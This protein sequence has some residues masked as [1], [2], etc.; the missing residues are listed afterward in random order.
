[1]FPEKIKELRQQK[2]FTQKDVAE[3]IGV[4]RPAYTAYEIGKRQPDFE[5]L[6]K[7]A[8]LYEV[9]TDYLLGNEAPEE[10]KASKGQTVAAHIDE[11]VSDEEMEDILNY[12]EFIRQ[13]HK[14]E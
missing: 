7:I 6:Q 13:K 3:K 12:I 11:D 14:K 5:T 2:K 1:M 9:T 4:T 10:E 8:K